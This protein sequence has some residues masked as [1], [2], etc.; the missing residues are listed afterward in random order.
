MKLCLCY[1][2]ICENE[3]KAISGR[4]ELMNL[5]AMIEMECAKFKK[6]VS[7]TGNR[8]RACWVRAS[9]PNH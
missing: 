5:G 6:V 3:K 9:Y 7:G 4:L 8:A 2:L 1:Y